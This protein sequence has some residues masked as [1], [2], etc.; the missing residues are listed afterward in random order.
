MRDK[1]CPPPELALSE[2]AGGQWGVVAAWQLRAA[3]LTRAAISRR[4]VAGPLHPL[5]RGVYAVGHA[6]LGA[7][8]RRLAAVLACGAGAVLSHKSAAAHWNLL[9]TSAAR[10]D[11]TAARGRR[12]HE[13]IRLH[14]SRSLDA[15]DT[16]T[17]RAIPTTTIARTLLDLAAILPAHRLERALGQAE[18]LHLYDHTALTEIVQRANGHRG[19]GALRKAIAQEPAFTRSEL[20]ARLLQVT[21]E[22]GLPAP[23][24]NHILAAPDHPRLEVDFSWPTHHLI[25]ETDTYATHGTRADFERDRRRDAALTAAGYTVIRFTD[26]TELAEITARLRSL[27]RR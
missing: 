19:N 13:G 26:Q 20:E 9:A 8:G 27:L 12:A 7:E 16:T 10:I 14:R 3:G 11:V 21:R 5:H 6:H 4:V 25:V 23:L 18:R 22:H 2:L 1:R 15:Q 24:V 17:H